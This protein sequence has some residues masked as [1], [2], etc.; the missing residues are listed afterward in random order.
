MCTNFLFISLSVGRYL[1]C[2]Y[3]LAIVNNMNMNVQISV[4]I[5]AFKRFGYILKNRIAG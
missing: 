2:F 4:L 1:G 5:P 3:I